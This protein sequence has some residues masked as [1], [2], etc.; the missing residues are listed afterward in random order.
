MIKI[1]H[2]TCWFC[3]KKFIIRDGR[4]WKY[5]CKNCFHYVYEILEV[6]ER[7]L[8]L[9]K[10]WSAIMRDRYIAKPEYFHPIIEE[11]F[12][13]LGVYKDNKER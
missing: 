4:E 7:P 6:K 11:R 3:G 12:K 13:S 2:A 5:L 8:E 10:N 9:K 1:I